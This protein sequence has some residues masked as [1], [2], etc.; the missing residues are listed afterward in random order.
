MSIES[1]AACRRMRLNGAHSGWLYTVS[2]YIVTFEWIEKVCFISFWLHISQSW[3]WY[4]SNPFISWYDTTFSEI[5]IWIILF[6]FS[7]MRYDL[8]FWFSGKRHII[9]RNYSQSQ[10]TGHTFFSLYLAFCT[11]HCD[12]RK[13]WTTCQLCS[14]ALHHSSVGWLAAKFCAFRASILASRVSDEIFLIG[15]NRHTA[16]SEAGSDKLFQVCQFVFLS[17]FIK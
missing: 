9:S 1:Y 3:P 11:T 2:V 7:D 8:V 16:K 6:L 15:S 17:W 10:G 13:R 5:W 12:G 14:S 4:E